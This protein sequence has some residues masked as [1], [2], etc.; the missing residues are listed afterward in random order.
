IVYQARKVRPNKTPRDSK[1]SHNF[2][3]FQKERENTV[4]TN[5]KNRL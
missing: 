3:E 1:A 4:I 2:Q 5:L